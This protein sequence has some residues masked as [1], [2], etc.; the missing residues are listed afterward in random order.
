MMYQKIAQSLAVV[1]LAVLVFTV[2]AT[3]SDFTFGGQLTRNLTAGF[4]AMIWGLVSYALWEIVVN[5][6]SS[7]CWEEGEEPEKIDLSGMFISL[8]FPIVAAILCIVAI[9]WWLVANFT[10]GDTKKAAT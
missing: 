6:C 3:I 1:F 8:L 4:A 5:Y 10:Q 2:I 9:I 7:L